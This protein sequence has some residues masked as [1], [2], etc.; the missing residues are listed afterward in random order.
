VCGA[1]N[2]GLALPV[3][4]ARGGNRRR[5]NSRRGR[6]PFGPLRTIQQSRI[7]RARELS[8]RI[9]RFSDAK[10]IQP[11]TFV[12]PMNHSHSS[13]AIAFVLVVFAL[14]LAAPRTD[15]VE[16][17]LLQ[18]TYVDNGTTGSK[19]PPNASNYGSGLDLRVFKGNGRIGRT[20]L[21]FTLATLPP[22]T[23]S[24][25]VTHARLRFWVNSNSTIAGAITLSPVTTAWDEYLLKD[26]TTGSL[27][28]GTPRFSELAVSSV[29]NFISIDVTDWVKAWLAGTLVNQGILVE[30][31]AATATLNLAFDS[32]ESNLTS[33]EPR[34]EI[35]LSRIGPIGA[36]GPIGPQ[37]VAG[38]TGAP[39]GPGPAGATGPAGPTGLVGPDG[40]PGISG[41]DGTHWLSASGA[42][43]PEI[44]TLSDYYL[45]LASGDVWKKLADVQGTAVWTS[46][47]NIRGALGPAGADG[48][49]GPAGA[50][51]PP[52][53]QGAPGLAGSA[54]PPGI[55]GSSGVQG[56]AGPPGPAA[57]WP[58]RILPQ[59][60]LSMGEF[61]QGSLP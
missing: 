46:Q 57:I 29:N 35:V 19:P 61:T 18:D 50:V 27:T 7:M 37:G 24:S 38:P 30:P 11:I 25:D 52:G 49:V 42:P 36:I 17:L 26:N 13:R 2:A 3:E 60:D 56:P 43:T 55:P 10:I 32:K 20:F 12:S 47:G 6:T 44:G 45:D 54:G 8:A 23:L 31:S 39:G 21:K 16:A 5:V 48:Q 53:P 41:T 59:G 22:G 1:S 34:L 15:A 58:T 28:F 51:G 4:P 40:S 9:T 33:H 14:G